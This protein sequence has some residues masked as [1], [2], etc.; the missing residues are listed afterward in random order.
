[1]GTSPNDQ[2]VW[3]HAA[4]GLWGLFIG[5]IQWYRNVG[6]FGRGQASLC[7][8]G[9][10]CVQLA[11]F[12]GHVG[13]WGSMLCPTVFSH[14]LCLVP[15]I[16]PVSALAAGACKLCTLLLK[17][18]AMQLPLQ[19]EACWLPCSTWGCSACNPTLGWESSQTWP[20]L[21]WQLVVPLA[22]TGG[23][24]GLLAC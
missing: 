22:V 19:C 6:R 15:G 8:V 18:R 23:E 4:V 17:A 16:P 13:V 9:P 14:E 21:S 2:H 1:M 10:A 3:E 24:D 20:S 7:C 12:W 5:K 11:G